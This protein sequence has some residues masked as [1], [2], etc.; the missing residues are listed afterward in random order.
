MYEM[1]SLTNNVIKYHKAK[2]PRFASYNER[3]QSYLD[4][5]WPIAL[6]Q[7]PEAM[8]EAGFRYLGQSDV[9]QCFYCGG[10]LHKW[11]PGDD[12]WKEHAKSYP[13]CTFLNLMKTPEYVRRVNGWSHFIFQYPYLSSMNKVD[14]VKNE[15][16]F[17]VNDGLDIK[18][19]KT[20]FTDNLCK[21]L[22]RKSTQL[23]Q[24]NRRLK[25][26][27]LCKICLDREITIVL[28]PCG[29]FVSCNYCSSSISNCPICRSSINE[30]VKTYIS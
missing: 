12:P 8:A 28:I 11:L 6:A 27:R 14:P 26:E 3:M 24:E 30:F 9:V 2:Y 20:K 18:K 1:S 5:G 7:K 29:H 22:S 10:S 15:Y 16:V 21:L 19:P 17:T 4:L 13:D 23:L 25:E